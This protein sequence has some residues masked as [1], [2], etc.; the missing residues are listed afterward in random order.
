MR[1]EDF[2]EIPAR[3]R[4][5]QVAYFALVAYGYEPADFGLTP[6]TV[7]LGAFDINKVKRAVAPAFSWSPRPTPT[8]RTHRTPGQSR[9]PAPAAA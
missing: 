8:Q 5:R 2:D 9:I 4:T 1:L 3:M 7:A 6:D